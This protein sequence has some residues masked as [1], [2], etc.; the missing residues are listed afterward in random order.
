MHSTLSLRLSWRLSL[1][2][3]RRDWRAGELRVLLA[4][5][6]IAVACVSSVAFFTDRISQALQQQT[7]ELLG[8]DLR[9]VADRP[10]ASTMRDL[11]QKKHLATTETRSFRSMIVAGEGTRLAEIKA[12][13]PGYPLRGA[14]KIA[15]AL[16]AEDQLTRALPKQ[17]E[18]WAGPQLLQQLSLQVGEQLQVGNLMLRI[19]AV[20]TYEPDRSGNLFSIAPRL[21]INLADLPATGLLQEGSHIH[22]AL[23]VAGETSAIDDF[24]NMLTPQLRRGE[25]IEGAADARP[26]VRAAL[27]RA[28]Q[29]LGLAAVV[30]VVLACVAIAL[31]ARRF[32]Q[33]HRNTCAMLRCFGASQN[34]INAIFVFQLLNVKF[35]K[36]TVVAFVSGSI[37]GFDV[38]IIGVG[39]KCINRLSGVA[40]VIL[41]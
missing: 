29:F 28:Q 15:P 40:R 4:A 27:T 8:A 25:R 38:P 36:G 17:G 41:L 12:A 20:L 6:L 7:G 9:V 3:L 2:L 30:A 1:R 13:G 21:L 16:F 5:V 24:R 26:E 19:S 11:A 23:L 14:L 35:S 22:Y 10:L 32:A 33:R 39:A 34:M 18:A 31:S 37:N